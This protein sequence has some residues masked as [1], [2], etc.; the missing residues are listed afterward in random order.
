MRV[1]VDGLLADPVLDA[2]K[3]RD[4]LRLM[5][6]ENARLSRLIENF[7][8]FSRLDR[9]RYQFAMAPAD[10]SAIVAAAV[11]AVR[12][13]LPATATLD[14]QVEPSLPRVM[15]DTEA[16]GTALVNL[17]DNALKYTPEQK[18]IAVRACRDG[19]GFVQFVVKDNGIGIPPREQRRV[20]RRFYRV[21]QR[22][23]RETGGVGLGLSIVELIAR[24]HGGTATVRSE[25]GAGSTFTLRM[26][27]AAGDT[28]A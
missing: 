24:G 6:V 13:R 22:L 7:L 23:A 25:P 17:L 15:V 3:T 20:F 14:V 10:P 5:A 12:D 27:Q 8:T 16:V 11:D 1:L 2:A 26:P 19:A 4:Y 18:R 28:A 9:G 21:D